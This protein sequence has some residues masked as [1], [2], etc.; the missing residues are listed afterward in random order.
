VNTPNKIFWI[1]RVFQLFVHLLPFIS[2][3][4][5]QFIVHMTGTVFMATAAGKPYLFFMFY[6]TGV[7]IK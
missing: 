1:I 6:P 3:D 4:N 7:S 2:L 5:W